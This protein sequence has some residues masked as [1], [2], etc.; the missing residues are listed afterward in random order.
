MYS[1]KKIIL[2]FTIFLFSGCNYTWYQFNYSY[3]TTN[4]EELISNLLSKA[5]NQIFPNMGKSEVL[6]VSNFAETTTLQSN[7]KLSF[8]LSDM[9]KNQLVSKYSYTV[10]DIELSNKFRLGSDGFKV[11]TRDVTQIN[12]KITKA[13][14]A[15]VGVYTFT[16]NQILLFLKVI[17]IRNGNIVASSNHATD[18]T[19]D[20]VQLNKIAFEKKKTDSDQDSNIYQPLVL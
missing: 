3:K 6:L 15:V 7:T 18:L 5:S 4:Y 20:I 8:V 14:Y 1:I 2:L 11:L 17:N 19:E 9:L 16:K 12:S 13:K 10:R